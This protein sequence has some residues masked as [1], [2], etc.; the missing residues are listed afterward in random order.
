[1]IKSLTT[2]GNSKAIILPKNLVDKYH[3]DQVSIHEVEEGILIKPSSGKPSFQEKLR[4]LKKR[5]KDVYS[6]M[7]AQAEEPEVIA[8]YENEVLPDADLDII[9]SNEQ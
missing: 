6:R 8:Y 3:L 4:Q 2:I 7:K 9:D 5:K 1:M